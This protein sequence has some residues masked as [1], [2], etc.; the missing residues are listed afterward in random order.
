MHGFT[1]PGYFCFVLFFFLISERKRD[2][3]HHNTGAFPGTVALRCGFGVE[4]EPYIDL[5]STG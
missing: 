2:S 3:T 5:A 4:T 1:A